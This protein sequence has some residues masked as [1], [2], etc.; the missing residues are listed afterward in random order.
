MAKWSIT[1]QPCALTSDC[2]IKIVCLS[3]KG[4]GVVRKMVSDKTTDKIVAMVITIL[5]T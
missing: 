4:S 1:C 3:L 2:V 5:H